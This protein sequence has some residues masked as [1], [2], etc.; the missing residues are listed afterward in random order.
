MTLFVDKNGNLLKLLGKEPKWR[1]MRR[2]MA[3][4]HVASLHNKYNLFEKIGYYDFKN[5]RICADYELLMRK[6]DHL[7]YIMITAHIARM[8][9]G[10]MSFSTKAIR[11]TFLIRKKHHSVPCICN[12]ILYYLDLLAYKFFI[13]RKK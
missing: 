2:C 13:F 8:S 9:V 11:E 6:K 5:F 10:G 3:P 1:T 7:K 12:I 4:A